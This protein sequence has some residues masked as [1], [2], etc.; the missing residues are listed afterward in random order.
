[1][2]DWLCKL[3]VQVPMVAG[4]VF[5]SMTCSGEDIA[6]SE[7]W[8]GAHLVERKAVPNVQRRLPRLKPSLARD[9]F[10]LL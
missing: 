2:T 7:G 3:D 10:Y 1:M 4:R 6:G 9:H 8:N 5:V